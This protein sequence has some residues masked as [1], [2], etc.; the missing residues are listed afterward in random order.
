MNEPAQTIHHESRWPP[1][2]AILVVLPHAGRI[3]GP[4][5]RIAGLGFRTWLRSRFLRRWAL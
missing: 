4:R 2:L 5:P 1:A 3:T